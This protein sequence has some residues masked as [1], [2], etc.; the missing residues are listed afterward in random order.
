[1]ERVNFSHLCIS[2]GNI[3]ILE[4]ICYEKKHQNYIFNCM[5]IITLLAVFPSWLSTKCANS[6]VQKKTTWSYIYTLSMVN[7]DTKSTLLHQTKIKHKRNRKKNGI[8]VISKIEYSKN[9][10]DFVQMFYS[11]GQNR[12][13]QNLL[14]FSDTKNVLLSTQK[15]TFALFSFVIRKNKNAIFPSIN[16]KL[17]LR[18]YWVVFE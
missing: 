14:E 18:I 16:F 4:T 12:D 9:R 5:Y 10:I 7:K 1:M 15:E 6:K 2:N 8:E 17:I 13:M 3:I 11:D